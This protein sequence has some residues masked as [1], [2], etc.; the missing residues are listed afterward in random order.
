MHWH[1][2]LNYF[3]C[4]FCFCS[5]YCSYNCYFSIFCLSIRCYGKSE[6]EYSVGPNSGFTIMF[7]H[8]SKF[9]TSIWHFWKWQTWVLVNFE[10]WSE[11]NERVYEL[12]HYMG[13]LSNQRDPI[14]VFSFFVPLKFS[15]PFLLST[16]L[17]KTLVEAR[18][19]LKMIVKMGQKD[20]ISLLT[21]KSFNGHW[22]PKYA[23]EWRFS[24]V[25]K[26]R[27]SIAIP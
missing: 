2:F 13:D 11:E 15:D 10:N 3:C 26:S 19:C 25:Y 22:P 6:N 12:T 20:W 27:S 8:V 17:I 1:Y 24:S 23:E 7:G 5:C 21:E 14:Q 4:Y 16:R 18:L 9:E